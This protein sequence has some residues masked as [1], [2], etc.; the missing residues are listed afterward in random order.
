MANGYKI[1]EAGDVID[2]LFTYRDTYNEKGKYLGFETLH[3]HYSM[4]LGNCTDWTGYPMSGKTQVLMELL[5]NTSMFYGWKHLIYFPDVG[6]NVEIIA[7]LIHKKT[8]KSFNPS[9]NNVITN[10]E[11]TWNIDWVIQHF[12]VL[13]KSDVKAKMTPIQFW[14]M[15][16]ELKKHGELHTASI[17]SWK[18]LTHEYEKHGGYAQYL[19]YVLPYRNQIAEDNNLHLH[20]IIHPKLTEK[21]NGKRAVPVPYDLKGGSE[22]FN[23]GKCMITVHRQ[24]PTHNL[25]E[26]H[27]N[28][29]KPRSNGKVGSIELWFDKERL[30]YFEQSNPAPNV[31]EKIYASPQN[32]VIKETNIHNAIQQNVNFDD[33]LPF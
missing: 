28:K 18:D 23:S 24:D 27:F 12:K 25:A 7:D 9:N 15:A 30:T 6:T 32:V 20:T 22:W 14:D 16:V 17:D 1:T 8:G 31:Y 3:E 21:V 10:E 2:K 33:K 13:T 11:I 29:I 19:E 5:I 26:I 4:S